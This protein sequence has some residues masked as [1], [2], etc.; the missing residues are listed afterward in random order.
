MMD[1]EKSAGPISLDDCLQ[2]DLEATRREIV[3]FVRYEVDRLGKDGVLVGF[4][5]GLDST[6][7]G[8]LCK[9][10]IG[11]D[12]VYG[13]ILPERDSSRRN[14]DDAEKIVKLLGIKYEKIDITP[15]L[16]DIGVYDVIKGIDIGSRAEV[17]GMIETMK[18][19]GHV[20]SPFAESYG[21]M[22]THGHGKEPMN[23]TARA[24][25]NRVTAS[26]LAKVRTRMIE[27]YFHAMLK[28]SLVAGTTDLSEWRIGFYDKYGDAACDIT[29]LKHL[30][31]TQIR[32]LARHIGVPDYI[33]DKPSSGDLFGEGLP[34][35]ALIGL[36]YETLDRIL[37]G[38]DIGLRDAA[39]AKAA[40]VPIDT[41][42]INKKAIEANKVH[43]SMQ[44]A[45][46]QR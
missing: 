3:D 9:E 40:G 27:L 35:E 36:S 14:M 34:N 8:F 45:P 12:R 38:M 25:T 5:G 46:G 26:S 16:E 7:V 6:T 37:C 23:R 24:I 39:I 31:K 33:T 18:R 15:V 41:V 30:Y 17:E 32:A 43:E 22:Y 20:Q 19:T 44:F 1:V 29:L 42:E 11:A 10:A 2:I 13:L 28:N 21:A 4:S